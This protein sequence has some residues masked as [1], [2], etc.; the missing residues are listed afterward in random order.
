MI[1]P[2]SH[3]VELAMAE[4]LSPALEQPPY[5]LYRVDGGETRWYYREDKDA[6]YPSVTSVIGATTPTPYG[7]LQ[8]MKKHGE[9]ADAERDKAAAYGTWLHIQIARLLINKSYDMSGITDSLYMAA[10]D[11]GVRLDH[12]DWV[13]RGQHDILSFE[14]FRRDHDVT[15]TAIEACLTSDS[16]Y[17]GAVDLVCTM[18]IGTGR[19]GAFLKR[20][21]GGQEITAIVD[22]KSGRKGFYESH[23]IQ[24]HMYAAMV[25]ENFGITADRLYN[26][27][28]SDWRTSPTFKLKDQTES[29]HAAKIPHLLE[30]FKI[31]G[32]GGPG[33]RLSV[34]GVIDPD[35]P[36]TDFYQLKEAKTIVT[37]K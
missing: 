28:P 22:F 8:W 23:E 14:Q 1:A 5:A 27:S 12:T 2:I 37:E 32:R 29:R 33:K 11:A 13:N 17:A 31:E 10:T 19:N 4:F 7:L 3:E 34:S 15:P 26:W 21:N 20:D 16:G 24:L 30:I 35:K 6:Y 9:E 36:L 25:R 18:K